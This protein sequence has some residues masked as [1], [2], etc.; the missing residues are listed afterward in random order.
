M[1]VFIIFV[2]VIILVIGFIVVSNSGSETMSST[3]PSSTRS[4]EPATGCASSRACQHMNLGEAEANGYDDSFCFCRAQNTFVKRTDHCS[5]FH[6]HGCNNG[7][8]TNSTHNHDT[9]ECYCSYYKC[10]VVPKESCPHYQD[11]FDTAIG[12]HLIESIRREHN[13]K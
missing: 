12:Q 5:Y 1:T 8:C 4:P 7:A 6:P 3:I 13:S 9:G 2:F 11:F 10:N